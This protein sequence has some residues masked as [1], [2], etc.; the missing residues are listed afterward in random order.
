LSGIAAA[1]SATF[2]A[3]QPRVK[4]LSFPDRPAIHVWTHYAPIVG[5]GWFRDR[6]LC[7]FGEM[8]QPL[9]A[10][11]DAWSFLVPKRAERLIVGR[12]AHGAIAFVDDLATAAPR[13]YVV[14]PLNV[15]LLS[16]VDLNLFTFIDQYLPEN[17]IPTLTDDR[18]YRQ[19]RDKGVE[20]GDDEILAIDVPLTLG[21][22]AQLDNFHVENILEHYRATGPI[23]AKGFAKRK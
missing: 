4:P 22:K 3:P 5:S 2:G 20:L 13:L 21:G 12:N 1:F 16:D 15:D 10:C 17:R 8:L 6:F 18:I 23:Y 19:W 14:D 11:L 9:N 7:L